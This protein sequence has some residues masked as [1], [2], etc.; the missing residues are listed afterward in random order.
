MTNCNVIGKLLFKLT[1]II[2]V[3]HETI[4][5]VF[6][7]WFLSFSIAAIQRFSETRS[8]GANLEGCGSGSSWGI[9]ATKPTNQRV[10]RTGLARRSVGSIKIIFGEIT[11]SA[12]GM[13]LIAIESQTQHSENSSECSII[14]SSVPGWF[15]HSVIRCWT[16]VEPTWTCC[17]VVTVQALCKF[18]KYYKLSTCGHRCRSCGRSIRGSNLVRYQLPPAPLP[19]WA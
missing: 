2:C 8:R 12:S 16:N 14:L 5:T 15:G 11:Q 7:K 17:L 6:E 18:H 4:Q 3:I 13:D 10:S 19:L 1:N 9:Q